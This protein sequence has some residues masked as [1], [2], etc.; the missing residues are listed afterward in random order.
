MKTKEPGVKT[1]FYISCIFLMLQCEYL[2]RIFDNC[3]EVFR[4]GPQKKG[5]RWR[6]PCKIRARGFIREEQGDNSCI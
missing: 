6:Q 3:R 5:S 1:V 2:G 4:N